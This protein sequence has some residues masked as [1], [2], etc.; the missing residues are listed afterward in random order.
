VLKEKLKIGSNDFRY[1]GKVEGKK[2][3]Q[4][5]HQ[6][7]LSNLI[8]RHNLP[9]KF[10]EYLKLRTWTN[11]LCPDAIMISRNIVKADIGRMY[12]KEKIMLKRNCLLPFLV[13]YI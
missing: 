5:I 2:K 10:V 8:S 7:L 6:E 3:N 1:A 13:G 11:Y 12:M 4:V 9:Y